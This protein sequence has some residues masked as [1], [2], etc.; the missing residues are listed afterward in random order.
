M[1]IFV[2]LTPYL[3]SLAQLLRSN[4]TTMSPRGLGDDHHSPLLTRRAW[5]TAPLPRHHLLLM[6]S[7]R[8]CTLPKTHAC[9]HHSFIGAFCSVPPFGDHLLLMTNNLCLK[10]QLGS[11]LCCCCASPPRILSLAHRGA[12]PLHACHPVSNRDRPRMP[13]SCCPSLPWHASPSGRLLACHASTWASHMFFCAPC[14]VFPHP[15][16]HDKLQ[17]GVYVEDT[18]GYVCDNLI[19]I[20]D[21][22]DIYHELSYVLI[23]NA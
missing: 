12:L 19:A 21:M 14:A 20:N 11:Q 8:C 17:C 10:S 16:Q 18:L 13:C 22:L 23:F 7:N 5:L 2:A 4:R 15:D 9:E 6:T 1:S 3:T